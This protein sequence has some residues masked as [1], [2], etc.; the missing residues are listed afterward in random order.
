MP[1][2]IPNA[3]HVQVRAV[4][5]ETTTFEVRSRSHPNGCT[6]RGEEHSGWY[7]VSL[8]DHKGCGECSCKR[9]RTV[10]WPRI[11][12]TGSLPPLLRCTHLRAAR[13]LYCTQ[14]LAE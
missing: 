12:D 9:W 14:K 1:S 2:R 4:P 11:R 3:Q 10:C 6:I 8:T 7:L 5:W 13:E